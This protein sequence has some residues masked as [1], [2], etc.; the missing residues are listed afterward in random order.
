MFYTSSPKIGMGDR[1]LTT[2]GIANNI[3]AVV[4]IL[5]LV[6]NSIWR[7]QKSSLRWAMYYLITN[8]RSQPYRSLSLSAVVLQEWGEQII[9]S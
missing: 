3:G 4:S 6:D 7:L 2:F 8:K 5:M 1:I 9:C